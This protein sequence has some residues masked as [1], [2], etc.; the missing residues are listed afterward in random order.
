MQTNRKKKATW[1][2]HFYRI[3]MWGLN[4]MQ[5]H[6]HLLNCALICFTAWIH[7]CKL[8]QCWH[9][10][11]WLAILV[12]CLLCTVANT[13]FWF[14]TWYRYSSSATKWQKNNHYS[15]WSLKGN[16]YTIINRVFCIFWVFTVLNQEEYKPCKATAACKRTRSVSLASGR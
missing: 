6:K 3:S 4:S 12:C 9:P 14:P 10:I 13:A 2:C 11:A 15:L 7:F 16:M 5:H 8:Q 1:P